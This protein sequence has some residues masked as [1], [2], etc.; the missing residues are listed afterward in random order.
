M[1]ESVLDRIVDA[2]RCRLDAEA[3]PADL[4]ERAVQARSRLP[5][6]S[7]RKALLAEGPSIIAECKK[8]SPSAGLLRAD[9]D[10][11]ALAAHYQAAGASAISVVTEADFFQGRLEWLTAVRDVV[12]LPVLRKDFVIDERQLREAAALG[13]DAVLLIQRILPAGRLA[14]LVEAAAEL[15]LET[16]VEI[17]A[18]EDPAA[19]VASGAEIIG[20][21][22]RDLATF[23][24]RLDVVEAMAESLPPDRVRVAE[25]GI[26]DHD[27]VARLG[28][29]G[30]DAF[31]IGE[32]LVR[33]DDPEKALRRLRGEV[34]GCQA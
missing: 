32:H 6:R 9:F 28:A 8:A 16:L 17:F 22:A 13:A 25:S 30:Y 15:E 23:V 21:N 14:E 5:K 7:F 1:P 2:V 29:A 12:D 19:A 18:D 10:P 11:S 31:L 3:E 20:V 34:R 24:T 26:K 27:D 4:A 33:A